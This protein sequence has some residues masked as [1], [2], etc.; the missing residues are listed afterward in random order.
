MGFSSGISVN[1]LWPCSLR[2]FGFAGDI[3]K[4][5]AVYNPKGWVSS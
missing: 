2:K 5:I 4:E 1:K 3:D